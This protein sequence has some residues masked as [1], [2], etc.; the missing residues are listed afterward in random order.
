MRHKKAPQPFEVMFDLSDSPLDFDELPDWAKDYILDVEAEFGQNPAHAG[1]YGLEKALK[2]G[3]GRPDPAIGIPTSLD[4]ARAKARLQ[5]LPNHVDP[6]LKNPDKYVQS[7]WTIEPMPTIDPHIWDTAVLTL[8]TLADLCG[9]DPFLKRSKIENKI[10]TMGQALAP[11]RSYAMCYERDNQTL[12]VDGH[13]R[14]MSLWLLGLDKAPV[15]LVKE[16]H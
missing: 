6:S 5:I 2:P 9:T 11:F 14:L 12:I 4:T 1:I 3:M 13:H 8:V 7:P 15:W 16:K 10:E